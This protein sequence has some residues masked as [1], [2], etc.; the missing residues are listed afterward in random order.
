LAISCAVRQPDF[1]FGGDFKQLEAVRVDNYEIG[2][3][4]NWRQVQASISGFY[5]TSELGESFLLDNRGFP[6]G[7][8]ARRNGYTVLRELLTGGREGDGNSAVLQLGK[9]VKMMLTKM[10]T[11]CLSIAALS[12]R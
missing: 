9:K 12:H 10:E 4:G 2:V 8:T 1:R 3:R 5:N 6:I 11:I 7:I